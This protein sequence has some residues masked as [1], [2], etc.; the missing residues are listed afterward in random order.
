MRGKKK[1][2]FAVLLAVVAI[3]AS[4]QPKVYFTKDISPESLV[5]IYKAL[6]RGRE[7]HL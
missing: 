5:K 6:D 3:T 1:N 4:A 2:L 7:A